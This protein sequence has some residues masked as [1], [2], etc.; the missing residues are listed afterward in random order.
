MLPL[1]GA[2]TARLTGDKRFASRVASGAAMYVNL[3]HSHA[4]NDS[5]S[6]FPG[7]LNYTSWSG[8]L[9]SPYSNSLKTEYA[10]EG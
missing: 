7:L 2:Y 6:G 3:L 10:S 5:T 9:V 1:L 8:H 4:N